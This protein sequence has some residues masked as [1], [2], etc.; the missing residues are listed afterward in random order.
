MKC[1]GID[2]GL[3]RMGYGIIEYA[4][5]SAQL[6]EYGV[7]HTP[8]D[9]PVGDRLCMLQADLETILLKYPDI[10]LAGVEELFFAQNTTTAMVVSQ[11]RGVILFTLAK[12]GIPIAEVKPTE[13]K[14]AVTGNGHATKHEIQRMI[15]LTFNL[16]ALPKQD[17]AAD[18]IGI[19]LTVAPRMTLS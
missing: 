8:K 4:R 1:L 17:D 15:Q 2:P 7:A 12:R 9:L 3:E 6:L 14:A 13:V 19:A 16:S 11:A 18:A 10:A 5:G